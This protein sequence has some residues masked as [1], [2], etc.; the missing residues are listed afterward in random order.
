[1]NNNSNS[2]I[3]I[4]FAVLDDSILALGDSTLEELSR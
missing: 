1:M 2:T 3:E 4:I